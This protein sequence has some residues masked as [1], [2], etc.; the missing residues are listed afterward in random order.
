MRNNESCFT[1]KALGYFINNNNISWNTVIPYAPIPNDT[2]DR[3]V[4]TINMR[5]SNKVAV[6]GEKWES[7]L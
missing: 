3:I 5:F 2:E 7:S 6:K 1:S 4:G